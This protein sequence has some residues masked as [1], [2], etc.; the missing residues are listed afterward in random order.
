MKD[1]M[2]QMLNEIRYLNTELDHEKKE[3]RK[4]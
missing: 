1:S 4:L 3:R 2:Y